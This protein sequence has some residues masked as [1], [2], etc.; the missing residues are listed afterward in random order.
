MYER[1]PESGGAV[2]VCV[3]VSQRRQ[4][5]GCIAVFG[6]WM[7]RQAHCPAWLSRG[8]GITTCEAAKDSVAY[9]E[10]LYGRRLSLRRGNVLNGNTVYHGGDVLNSNPLGLVFKRCPFAII[11]SACKQ[12]VNG[13]TE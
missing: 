9:P 2:R 11:S 6:E 8:P 13:Y 10:R 12:N 5:I 4:E 1:L 7:S 3:N